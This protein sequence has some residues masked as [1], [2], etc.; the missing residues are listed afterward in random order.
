[1]QSTDVVIVGG[2]PAG[3]QAALILGRCRRK[4]ILYNSGE[5]RNA[6][7]EKLSG[8]LS[9]DGISPRDFLELGRVDV[10]AYSSVLLVES[11]VDKAERVEDGFEVTLSDGRLCR[12]RKLL[13]TTG[14]SDDLPLVTGL[15]ELMGRGVY[16]CPYCDG[17]ECCDAAIAV[18]SG[19]ENGPGF[20]LE[21]TC[22]SQNVALLTDGTALTSAD[23]EK[24]ERHNVLIRCERIESLET[25]D[26]KLARILFCEGEPLDC[27]ALFLATRQNRKSQPLLDQLEAKIGVEL[28]AENVP[29]LFVAGDAH[30]RG[31]QMVASAVGEGAQ[32]AIKINEQLLK[33]DLQRSLSG[34][35]RQ[36]V[37]GDWKGL[38]Q[39]AKPAG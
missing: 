37:P 1:M 4:V 30:D 17:W 14:L 35:S 13:V 24:L 6:V 18:Y 19:K 21:M 15:P 20:A 16:T 11:R 29:G 22:W 36:S 23:R 28:E 12:C 5:P 9:R 25:T 2:G 3:L 10:E 31:V 38:S 27:I 34:P 26:G 7:A 33:E 8:F 39:E 32:V